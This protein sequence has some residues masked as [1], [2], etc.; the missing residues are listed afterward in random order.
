ML[1]YVLTCAHCFDNVAAVQL[2]LEEA[3][4][5]DVHLHPYEL[6]G[7]EGL[8]GTAFMAVALPV[9]HG[10]P[11]ATTCEHGMHMTE[12]GGTPAARVVKSL[13]LAQ[14]LNILRLSA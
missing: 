9:L 10:L 13:I 2:A 3:L 7:W 4:L 14:T 12:Y 8:F 6:L 5:S 1:C 11:G